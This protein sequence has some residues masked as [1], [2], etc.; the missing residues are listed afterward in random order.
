MCTELSISSKTLITYVA[1]VLSHIS[2]IL[3]SHALPSSPP[4]ISPSALPETGVDYRSNVELYVLNVPK[5]SS[6]SKYRS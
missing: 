5:S 2:F 4:T 3:Y 6:D 1:T